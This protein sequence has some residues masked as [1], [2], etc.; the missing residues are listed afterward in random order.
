MLKWIQRNLAMAM[1]VVAVIAIMGGVA[2][3]M[4]GMASRTVNVQRAEVALARSLTLVDAVV[5]QPVKA[6]VSGQPR[7]PF[8]YST[9]RDLRR[10]LQ[11]EVDTLLA[12]RASQET[13]TI[14]AAVS[15]LNADVSTAMAILHAHH[16]TIARRRLAAIEQWMLPQLKDLMH[17]TG[18]GLTRTEQETRQRT[19]LGTVLLSGSAGALLLLVMVVTAAA[20]RRRMRTEV[21][22]RVVRES[23]ARLRLLMQHDSDMVTVIAPDM[24]VLY[25]AGSVEATL[26]HAPEELEGTSLIDWLDPEDAPVLIALCAAADGGGSEGHELRLRRR[27]GSLCVCEARATSLL[28][29]PIWRGIILNIRDIGDRKLLEERLRHQAFHDSLTGL[30]NRVLFTDRLEHALVRAA[31]AQHEI[32]VLLVDLDDFKSVNDSLGHAA[33]DQLLREVAVRMRLATRAGDTVARL[34]GDEFAIIADVDAADADGERTAQRIVAALAEP[35]ELD[36]RSYPLSASVGVVHAG[37]DHREADEVVRDADMAMYSAKSQGKGGWAAYHEETHLALQDRLQLK[38]DLLHAL[39]AGDELELHYQPVV[40]LDDG[41]IVGLEALLRWN[42]PTR[43]Q[44][45]PEEFIPLA[46]ETGAIVQIGRWVLHEAC[47]QLRAWS[48]AS[49][50][51]LTIAVNVSARQLDGASLID[52]VEDALRAARLSPERLV[53]EITETELM[54]HID[55]A[56]ATLGTLRDRG[57]RIAVDDFGTG[58]CSLSQLERL[59]VDIIKLDRTFVSATEHP[60]EG[61]GL[62]RAVMDIGR[63]LHLR[64]VAEGIETTEQLDELRSLA[65]PLGQGFLFS[66]PLPSADVSTLLAD[67]AD[68][69][70]IAASIV[71]E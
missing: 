1:A 51:E 37:L 54:R 8:V 42:H 9:N 2:V 71:A 55:A 57:V 59:P 4:L 13:R 6:V 47:R 50:S 31:R 48:D 53:L 15:R 52:D 67:H 30:A 19:V 61:S 26:G 12:S 14:H 24:T 40:T 11:R 33:G 68:Q 66:R 45:Q 5:L 62:L 60:A 25:Q 43:G 10:E 44:I 63:S 35:V 23:E 28:S 49:G 46:E 32:A 22:E 38:A 20:K 34:G 70:P 7:G 16:L 56:V 58:Y 69:L 18:A 17:E 27:D 36:G 29:D 21:E 65:C 3:T 41:T 64:T 39:A